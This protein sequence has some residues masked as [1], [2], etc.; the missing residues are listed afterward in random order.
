M[1]FLLGFFPRGSHID[2]VHVLCACLLG[3]FLAKFGTA[4]GGFSSDE[5]AQIKK[6]KMGVFWA[7]YCKKHPIWA[8]LGAFLSK[9]VY[10]WVGKWAKIGI[11]KSNFRGSASTSRTVLAKVIPPGV[12]LP[13]LCQTGGEKSIILC[14]STGTR[15]CVSFHHVYACMMTRKFPRRP[16]FTMFYLKP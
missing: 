15:V 13:L 16:T 2:L 1:S 3:C 8:K 14:T 10:W 12:L 6:K 11:E 5:G 4:I 9:K 7:N